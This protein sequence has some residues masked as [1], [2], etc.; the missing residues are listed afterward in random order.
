[1]NTRSFYR[2]FLPIAMVSLLSFVPLSAYATATILSHA[3]DPGTLLVVH[4][5]VY[6][7]LITGG[8]LADEGSDSHALAYFRKAYEMNP[9][10]ALAA[11]SLGYTLMQV[12]EQ[13]P[14][15]QL[16]QAYRA[17]AEWS[18]LRARDLNPEL[19]LTYFKLGTLALMRE[20]S[21]TA[22][23][24]YQS[25]VDAN[26]ENASLHFNLAAAAEK[27][28]NL[29]KAEAAYREVIRLNPD[30][31]YAYN[32][33]GLILERSHRMEEAEA[34]YRA[35]LKADPDYNFARLNLGSLLQSEGRTEEA[36]AMY[37]ESVKLD[38][39]NAW[40]YFYL[41]NSY[42]RQGEFE[43]ALNAYNQSI[44]LNPKYA[45]AYY[46]VS[47]TLQ[48]L[49][50]EDEALKRGMQYIHLAPDGAF[51][52]EAGEMVMTLKQSHHDTSAQTP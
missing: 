3:D 43:A 16:K 28:N 52:Q 9:T 51:S 30:F 13:T 46:L 21:Q 39:K 4:H 33:L 40:G 45:P 15:A 37:Q 47:L 50:R 12:A 19:T 44:A 35:A 27:L 26:P 25:G 8:K 38:P 49:N 18:L 42:Y 6:G 22:M 5:S 41:G 32:N 24:Y 17:Q 48:K 34:V 23:E 29:P 10:S 2:E 11:Y 31:V 20:D 36:Q 14:S 7:S 1:M